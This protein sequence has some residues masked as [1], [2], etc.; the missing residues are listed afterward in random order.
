[1]KCQHP[2]ESLWEKET[3]RIF[4]KP[5]REVICKRCY[6]T[7][8]KG[9]MADYLASLDDSVDIECYDNEFKKLPI[10][11][12]MSSYPGALDS[13]IRRLLSDESVMFLKIQIGTDPRTC[14]DCN[15]KM[16]LNPWVR[17]KNRFPNTSKKNV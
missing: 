10:S 11:S 15:Q 5:K 4:R 16:E 14:P 17:A 2:L 13:A 6:E 3:K 12:S 9:P 1:M 7:I 8:Y